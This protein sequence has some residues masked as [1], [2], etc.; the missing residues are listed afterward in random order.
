MT[1]QTSAVAVRLF[2]PFVAARALRIPTA[3]ALTAIIARYDG[4]NA[5]PPDLV[6][7]VETT[8]VASERM[9]TV[10][11]LG[12][13]TNISPFAESYAISKGPG[14]AVFVVTTMLVASEIIEVLLEL[15]VTTK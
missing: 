4:C 15:G 3:A 13:D 7:V 8:D 2:R 1:G 12:F 5:R 10:S 14:P 11:A 6:L 9:V